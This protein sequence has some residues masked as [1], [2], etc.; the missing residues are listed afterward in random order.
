M[1]LYEPINFQTLRQQGVSAKH[2]NITIVKTEFNHHLVNG[3]EWGAKK[4]FAELGGDSH[5]S[6]STITVPGV[7]ELPLICQR[8]AELSK[9][10]AV[11]ALGVVIRGDT[12]HFDFVCQIG[13]Q[14]IMQAMLKTNTPIAFGVLTTE[15]T[16][17]AEQRCQENHHNKGIE[18]M[19]AAIKMCGLSY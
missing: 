12:S 8:M 1:Q 7:V 2:F 11:V 18:A 6:C 19:V 5:H 4:A 10:D 15:N 14:G 3:L 9:I 16:Q 13:S 17:Q